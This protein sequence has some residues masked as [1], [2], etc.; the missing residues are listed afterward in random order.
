M[1]GAV[2]VREFL[3]WLALDDDVIWQFRPIEKF[4]CDFKVHAI[5]GRD[6]WVQ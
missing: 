1:R 3:D 6:V 5:D 2:C 4:V